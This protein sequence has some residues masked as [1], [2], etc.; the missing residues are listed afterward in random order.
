MDHT[1]AHT[2]AAHAHLAAAI[3]LD[4]AVAEPTDPAKQTAADVAAANAFDHTV[5]APHA[6][7]AWRSAV[8]ATEALGEGAA[9]VAADHHRNAAR[10]HLAAIV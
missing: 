5:W 7:A 3:A 9:A 4:A 1:P 8:A 6:T 2:R 10:G